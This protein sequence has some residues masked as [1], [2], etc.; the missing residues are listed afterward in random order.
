MYQTLV[1][2]KVYLKYKVNVENIR[3]WITMIQIVHSNYI[4]SNILHMLP[5]EIIRELKKFL[6]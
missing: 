5:P 6:Y 4:P 1:Y 3:R 2:D